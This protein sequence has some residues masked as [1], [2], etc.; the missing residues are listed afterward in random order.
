VLHVGDEGQGQEG[1]EVPHGV[2]AAGAVGCLA[3]VADI[4]A[5]GAHGDRRSSRQPQAH[6]ALQLVPHLVKGVLHTSIRV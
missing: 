1:G 2:P 6:W 3:G 4:M 5:P